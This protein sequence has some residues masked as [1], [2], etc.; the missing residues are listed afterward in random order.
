MLFRVDNIKIKQK[1][2]VIRYKIASALT[3]FTMLK[4]SKIKEKRNRNS[5]ILLFRYGASVLTGL[6]RKCSKIKGFR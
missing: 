6:A 3:G 1:N 5:Q 2:P 4:P